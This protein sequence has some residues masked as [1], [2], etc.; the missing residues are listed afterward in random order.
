MNI[1]VILDPLNR[2]NHEWDNSLAVSAELKRRGHTL[3]TADVPDLH[4]K[5]KHLKIQARKLEIEFPKKSRPQYRSGVTRVWDAS[6]LDL[7]LIRKEPPVNRAYIEMTRKLELVSKKIPVINQPSGIRT[8]NEKLSI[9]NFPKWIPPNLVSSKR[10]EILKFLNT[11]KEI[12]VKPLDEKGG[13]G[14]FTMRPGG[15]LLQLR[16]LLRKNKPVMAQKRLFLTEG[17]GEKRIVLLNGKLLCAYEKRPVG[18]EWRGNLDLGATFHRCRLTSQEKQMLRALK[19][20]LLRHGLYFAGLDTI[21]GKLIE[22]NVTCP[23][24]ATESQFLNPRS[25]P[26][27]VW[28]DFLERSASS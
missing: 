7:I 21:N 8:Q 17:S 6:E 22:I 13:K 2:L 11:H 20:F 15:N 5:G 14:V 3:W 10:T 4:L 9:L 1:L 16:R 18:K 25:K 28:A 23:A 12:V 27:S 19:P 24:G 26:V